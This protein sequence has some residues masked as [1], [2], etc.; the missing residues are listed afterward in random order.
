L[1]YS[2]STCPEPFPTPDFAIPRLVTPRLVL[3]APVAEDFPAYAEPMAAPRARF[4]GGL[5]D[6][7]TAWGIF[8]HDV[9]Q[10]APFGHLACNTNLSHD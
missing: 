5:F 6:M 4:M 7:R 3:R 9:A 10:L 2:R 1:G 8:C